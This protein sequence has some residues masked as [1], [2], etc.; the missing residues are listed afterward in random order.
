M[1]LTVLEE[2]ELP[3]TEV[4]KLRKRDRD[5]VERIQRFNPGEEEGNETRPRQMVWN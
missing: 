2:R 4:F 3:V 1:E 5:A